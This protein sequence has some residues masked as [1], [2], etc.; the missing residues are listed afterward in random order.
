MLRVAIH[1][2]RPLATAASDYAV[3]GER[4]IG[5]GLLLVEEIHLALAV[6]LLAALGGEKQSTEI[7]TGAYRWA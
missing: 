6:E 4:R 3:Y 5:G 7:V 2:R 1:P